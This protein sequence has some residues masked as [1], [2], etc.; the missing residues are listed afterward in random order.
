MIIPRG[1]FQERQLR[2]EVRRIMLLLKRVRQT[3]QQARLLIAMETGGAPC[4]TAGYRKTIK[5]FRPRLR[6][7]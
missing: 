3:R 7:N 1:S 2:A 5:P 4:R 6:G